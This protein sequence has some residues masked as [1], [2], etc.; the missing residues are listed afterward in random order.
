MLAAALVPLGLG[1]GPSAAAAQHPD[2]AASG[3]TSTGCP[4]RD[5]GVE[6]AFCFTTTP[7]SAVEAARR[8][9]KVYGTSVVSDADIAALTAPNMT[10]PVGGG[11]S[12]GTC[13][14]S[15]C[16]DP[17]MSGNTIVGSIY[18]GT[19][20]Y[21]YGSTELGSVDL[22]V[23]AVAAG[24]SIR[25]YPL[26]VVTSRA[27]SNVVLSTEDLYLSTAHPDGN[28]Q[29]PP[30]YDQRTFGLTGAGVSNQ[31]PAQG[32][33]WPNDVAWVTVAGEATWSDYSSSY[34]GSWYV[35]A[36]S[37]KFER[38]GNGGYIVPAKVLP[39]NEAGGGWRA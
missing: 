31:W 22:Y 15:G 12:T 26:Y 30:L 25:T 2:Q 18:S 17:V 32:V 34:P 20:T 13:E 28:A 3:K 4:Q 23:K 21:W 11:G 19:G 6:N 10:E 36:K 14:I 5:A 8:V 7:A 9:Q 38:Q 35:W 29:S 39:T 27:R 1:V 37:Y 33:A 16:W 24:A